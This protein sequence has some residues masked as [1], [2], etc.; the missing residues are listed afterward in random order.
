MSESST[1]FPEVEEYEIG[2]HT[3]SDREFIREFM[4]EVLAEIEHEN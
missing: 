3:E 2:D 1:K 4:K